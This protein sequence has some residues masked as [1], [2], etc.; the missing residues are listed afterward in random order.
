MRVRELDGIRGL[1]VLMVIAYHSQ[2]WDLPPAAF[3]GYALR[4][5]RTV[6]QLSRP[7]WLGVDLFFVLSGFLITSIL[8]SARTSPHYYRTFYMRR[9]LR[10]VPLFYLVLLTI[11]F[12]FKHSTSYVLLAAVSL[13]NIAPLLGIAVIY[14]PLWS[15]C[16]E[17]HFYLLWPAIV[18]KVKHKQLIAICIGICILEPIARLA[19]KAVDTGF[20]TWFR[21][22][23]LASGALLAILAHHYG[24]SS[25][26]FSRWSKQFLVAGAVIFLLGVP[27]G[28]ARHGTAAN[29]ALQVSS[30]DFLF[31]ALISFVLANKSEGL[32]RVLL[33]GGLVL[34]GDLS[35]CLY[36]IHLL[37]F[38]AWDQVFT[39]WVTVPSISLLEL[40]LFRLLVCSAVAFGIAYVSQI[41]FERPILSLK[42][43]F[44]Y[45]RSTKRVR[46][47][48]FPVRETEDESVGAPE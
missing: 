12:S 38:W 11:W 35:Y 37:V 39:S 13:A 27:F 42:S 24:H 25:E 41:W 26:K 30:A 16:V 3:P 21:L 14:N 10:I 19:G 46:G 45:E 33:F 47:V 20:A 6:F 1:A 15:L 17:E 36:L 23:G 34:C 9:I 7:G 48:T 4:S 40:A 43:R 44:A 18:R 8:L 32:R 31:A 22:E 5:L 28:I 29:A 2:I